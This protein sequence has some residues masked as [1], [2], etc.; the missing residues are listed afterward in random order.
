[1]NSLGGHATKNAT[2]PALREQPPHEPPLASEAEYRPPDPGGAGKAETS[3]GVETQKNSEVGLEEDVLTKV[4]TR[5]QPVVERRTKSVH[6][7]VTCDL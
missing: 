5:C 6:V 1:M 2:G 4:N 7:F 3:Q